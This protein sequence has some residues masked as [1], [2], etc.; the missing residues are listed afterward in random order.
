MDN[1][2]HTLVGACLGQAGLKR[3]TSLG[4]ATLMIGANLPDIDVLSIPFGSDLGFR[5]GWTHGVLALSV[6]PFVLT[7]IM[8][9]WSRM[10]RLPE[11]N[12]RGLLLLSAISIVSH[13]LLDY[14][15]EYGLR[16]LMPF[17]GQW[18][19]ADTLFIVDPYLW[20]ALGLGV[21]LTRRRRRTQSEIA[22]RP[23]RVAVGF[24][25]IYIAALIVISMISRATVARALNL[26]GPSRRQLMV[27]P[28]P[29]T[30]FRWRILL[31]EQRRYRMGMLDWLASTRVSMNGAEIPRN[32]SL[33]EARTAANSSLGR[34]FLR[35]SRF[36]YFV[37]EPRGDSV[38]V[39]IVDA[40]YGSG[41]AD[42]WAAVSLV[43]P[44]GAPAGTATNSRPEFNGVRLR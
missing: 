38:L 10:R 17:S 5:R 26:D 25:A 4:M 36:P 31:A 14:M 15:N 33:P 19:Y 20:V 39:R 21:F 32:D 44:A 6:L 27:G 8:L 41:V 30:P 18:F 7:G 40:R 24:S 12:V 35:W 22:E 29:A 2:C 43:V 42:S 28:M 1:L 23:A 16:W 9:A 37:V 11:P 3:R 13:P 34:M